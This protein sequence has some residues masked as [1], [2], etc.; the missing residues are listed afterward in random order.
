MQIP[1]TQFRFLVL[2]S[3][4]FI[5]AGCGEEGGEHSEITTNVEK[6]GW[7]QAL[8]A[9]REEKDRMFAGA[10]SP[11]TEAAQFEFSG[12]QYYPPDSSYRR[13]VQFERFER[14]D[15]IIMGTSTGK[16]RTMLR[17]GLL[18][19]V[20]DEQACQL[21]LYKDPDNKARENFFIPFGDKTNGSETYEG[22]RYL[23][24]TQGQVKG[25]G[26]LDFNEA[27]NPYCAYNADWSCPIVPEENIL[28]V[29]V[30]AGE[31]VY[32]EE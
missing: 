29:S 4:L 5:F 22:G 10:S 25:E 2:Y 26:I 23:D 11:L 7:E 19:F 18:H 12:L 27:Y 32:V 14:T 8:I 20:L 17:V 9:T 3:A 30:Q 21:T 31:K 13:A 16:P 28:S 15:T 6:M 24:V 1:L